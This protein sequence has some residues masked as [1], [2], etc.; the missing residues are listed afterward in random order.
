MYFPVWSGWPS[1]PGLA[2]SSSAT[3]VESYTG[4]V[5]EFITSDRP[6][7]DQLILIRC[8]TRTVNYNLLSCQQISA[9]VV[10][11]SRARASRCYRHRDRSRLAW[12]GLWL[13]IQLRIRR[14]AGWRLMMSRTVL[15]FWL[16]SKWNGQVDGLVYACPD[17]SQVS[18][19]LKR[20][21]CPCALLIW[22]VFQQLESKTGITCGWIF[23][24]DSSRWKKTML[25]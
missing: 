1:L 20:L 12:G 17:M 7:H 24:I 9:A 15:M 14:G 22:N 16:P 8:I 5:K 23:G 2:S 6:L 13:M 25:R 11:K 19:G 4:Q 3:S 18:I 21:L 10:R